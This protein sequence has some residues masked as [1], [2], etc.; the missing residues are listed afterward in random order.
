MGGEKDF[1]KEGGSAFSRYIRPGCQCIPRRLCLSCLHNRRFRFHGRNLTLAAFSLEGRE[2]NEAALPQK[3]GVCVESPSSIASNSRHWEMACEELLRIWED[4]MPVQTDKNGDEKAVPG[5]DTRS[6]ASDPDTHVPEW[7]EDIEH[8][9]R[10]LLSER[11]K[12]RD[13]DPG[14]YL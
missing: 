13:K 3:P 8:T 10:R 4:A 5:A 2:S 14:L 9:L 11:Q 6:E 12:K 1:L 7:A